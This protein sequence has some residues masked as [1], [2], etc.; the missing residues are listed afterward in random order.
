MLIYDISSLRQRRYTYRLLY[1][2]Q[3]FKRKHDGDC[4]VR[5]ELVHEVVT[6]R[7]DERD[8]LTSLLGWRLRCSICPNPANQNGRALQNGLKQMVFRAITIFIH[9]VRLIVK[10][11]QQ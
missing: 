1:F 5:T 7:D 11:I 4:S 6:V 9:F 3:V 2:I 8:D 10:T